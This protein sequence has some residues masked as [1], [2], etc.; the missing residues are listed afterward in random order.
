VQW[1]LNAVLSIGAAFLDEC[2]GSYNF[3]HPNGSKSRSSRYA[4]AKRRAA[5][6]GV[7]TTK[8][9]FFTDIIIHTV[10]LIP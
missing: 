10:H 1:V 5:G 7:F 2:H 3:L 8:A 6:S 4:K 9:V